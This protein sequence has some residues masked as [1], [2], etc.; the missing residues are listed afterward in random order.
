MFTIDSRVQGGKE[1]FSTVLAA[2]A[3]GKKIFIE[4]WM[5][6]PSVDPAQNWGMKVGAIT[7]QYQ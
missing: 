3:A 4:T 7:I 5:G 1:Q 2:A 6:C